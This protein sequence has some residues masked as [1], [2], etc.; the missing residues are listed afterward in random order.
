[1]IVWRRGRI[2]NHCAKAL[3]LQFVSGYSGNA[4]QAFLSIGLFA[5]CW[6]HH[7]P[8][9]VGSNVIQIVLLF[10]TGQKL[11]IKGKSVSIGRGY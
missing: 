2:S 11:V 10:V 4:V 3:A 8:L 6:D 5:C 9:R 7:V 1:M